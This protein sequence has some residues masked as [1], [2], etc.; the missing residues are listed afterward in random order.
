MN[1]IFI[2]ILSTRTSAERMK[3]Q[4]RGAMLAFLVAS[5]WLGPRLIAQNTSE[6]TAEFKRLAVQLSA[7]RLKGTDAGEAQQEKALS[8]LDAMVSSVLSSSASP[9]LAGAN[10]RLAGLVSHDPPVGE[11]YHLVRLGGHA[12][13]YA[14]VVN[15]GLG[16]PAAVRVYAMENGRFGLGARIDQFSQKDFFDS[17]ITLVPVSTTQAAFVLVSG[18]TDDL[19]TGLFTV[20]R[21]DGRSLTLLWSSDL[22]LQSS[23]E[24]NAEGF[25][26]TY[27]S[28]PDDDHPAQCPRMS[29]DLYRFQGGDWKR[30]ATT[31]LGPLPGR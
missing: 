23:Y 30:V 6:S 2:R 19:S 8:L 17:D 15:F 11:S 12:A 1:L 5:V 13:V 28:Q 29:R 18:R 26:L 4:M 27:C 10:Q 14:L 31:D 25:H 16:G 21:F 9:D 3:L 20:W 22:L 7:A 24:T